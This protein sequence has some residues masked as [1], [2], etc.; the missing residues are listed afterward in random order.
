MD[1]RFKLRRLVKEI[2]LEMTAWCRVKPFQHV[3]VCCRRR[4]CCAAVKTVSVTTHD[5]KCERHRTT[6]LFTSDEYV[7]YNKNCLSCRV[8]VAEHEH[9][10]N[11][12]QVTQG[13]RTHVAKKLENLLNRWEVCLQRNLLFAVCVCVFFLSDGTRWSFTGGAQRDTFYSQSKLY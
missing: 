11:E 13:F 10:G 7:K 12:L 8:V 6:W 9:D 3:C 1:V 2:L 5:A 4:R